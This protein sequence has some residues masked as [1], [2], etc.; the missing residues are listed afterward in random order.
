MVTSSNGLRPRANAAAPAIE[1]STSHPFACSP[2]VRRRS[3]L[4]TAR[5]AGCFRYL[6]RP[7]GKPRCG[8]SRQTGIVK[9]S[10]TC[11]PARVPAQHSFLPMGPL[12]EWPLFFSQNNR[13]GIRTIGKNDVTLRGGGRAA[14]NPVA[15]RV[16]W[17]FRLRVARGGAPGGWRRRRSGEPPGSRKQLLSTSYTLEPA[18]RCVH[19]C[20]L[21][22]I[23]S[24]CS[25]HPRENTDNLCNSF[26]S[27]GMRK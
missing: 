15:C 2:H 12:A 14:S 7:Q 24:H 10:R 5:H 16:D 19:I 27:N 23:K 13:D 4:L 21:D 3:V 25:N 8:A 22:R 11:R 1:V 9:R 18:V 20:R 17:R 6:F 26:I